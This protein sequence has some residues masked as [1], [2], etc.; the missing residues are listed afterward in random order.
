MDWKRSRKLEILHMDG[1]C[2]NDV[3]SRTARV[4]CSVITFTVSTEEGRDANYRMRFTTSYRLEGADV[5]H[6]IIWVLEL[7]P[8][9]FSCGLAVHL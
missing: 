3:A 2:H 1:W 6:E 9:Q 4:N 8:C 7:G 5:V